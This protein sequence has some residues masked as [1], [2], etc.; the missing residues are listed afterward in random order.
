RWPTTPSRPYST[1]SRSKAAA[2]GAGRACATTVVQPG[3]GGKFSV[4]V[5]LLDQFVQESAGA[6][7]QR[8]CCFGERALFIEADDDTIG[9]KLK[10]ILA[11]RG[12]FHNLSNC[13][14][15]MG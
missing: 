13:C 11:D 5:A 2:Q 15:F 12:I 7:I 4:Q 6:G 8:F 9:F 14:G 1:L 3:G 10:G